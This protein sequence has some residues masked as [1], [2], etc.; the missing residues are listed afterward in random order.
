MWVFFVC[1]LWSVAGVRAY[2]L[3]ELPVF[4]WCLMVR[5]GCTSPR[6]HSD[7]DFDFRIL[8]LEWYVV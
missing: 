2:I 6:L 8:I 1:G 7:L 3:G 4:W 5:R